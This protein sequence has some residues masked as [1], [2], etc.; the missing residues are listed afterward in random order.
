MIDNLDGVQVGK[1][2]AP[3]KDAPEADCCHGTIYGV[4][5]FLRDGKG[6]KPQGHTSDILF[7][8]MKWISGSNQLCML[9][10]HLLESRWLVAIGVVTWP[11]A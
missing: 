1:A 4:T 7:T 6:G 3:C 8:G 10:T 9:Q 5:M 11:E 2:K